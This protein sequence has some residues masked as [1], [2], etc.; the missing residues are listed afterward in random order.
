[1]K[2]K[3]EYGDKL[4]LTIVYSKSGKFIEEIYQDV[5]SW[6]KAQLR[7]IFKNS[8]LAPQTRLG[9][10]LHVGNTCETF[11]CKHVTF[12]YLSSQTGCEFLGEQRLDW[13]LS[14][15]YVYFLAEYRI[16]S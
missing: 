5:S 10:L 13:L 9:A 12:T 4:S 6:F 2:V 1:M 15:L 11:T 8:C 7:V 14:K 16:P 3:F